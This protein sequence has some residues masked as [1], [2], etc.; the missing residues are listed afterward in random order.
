[1]K[2]S[3]IRAN[4]LRS[5]LAPYVGRMARVSGQRS[6]DKHLVSIT[7]HCIGGGITLVSTEQDSPKGY[8]HSVLEIVHDLPISKQVEFVSGRVDRIIGFSSPVSEK[9]IAVVEITFDSKGTL[10]ISGAAMPLTLCV[11]GEANSG[12]PEFPV[13]EYKEEWL[14]Q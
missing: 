4:Q 8:E 13:T 6:S 7:F 14:L 11:I 9:E 10:S 5:S 12:I 2:R 1:M 3:T